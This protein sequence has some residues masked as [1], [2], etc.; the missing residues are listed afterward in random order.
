[1]RTLI[2]A[3]AVAVATAGPVRADDVQAEDVQLKGRGWGRAVAAIY[4]KADKPTKRL[5][6]A[7]ALVMVAGFVGLGFWHFF[8]ETK[9]VMAPREKQPWEQ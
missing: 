6:V 2:L 7:G 4:N 5:Y 8:K 3:A 1:M 9:S